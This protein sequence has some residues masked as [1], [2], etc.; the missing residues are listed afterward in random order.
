M[1]LILE[2]GLTEIR[3]GPTRLEGGTIAA[4]EPPSMMQSCC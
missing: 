3:R 1:L 4:D 2:E